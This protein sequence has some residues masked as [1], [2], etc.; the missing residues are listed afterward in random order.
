LR[1]RY[2]L[3]TLVEENRGDAMTTL[4]RVLALAW[5]GGSASP[6]FAEDALEAEISISEPAEPAA[7]DE[8]VVDAESTQ[9]TR[10]RRSNRD[11]SGAGAPLEVKIP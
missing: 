8:L 1:S 9:S 4:W 3:G 2:R 11:S 10:A 7:G 6:A 5:L